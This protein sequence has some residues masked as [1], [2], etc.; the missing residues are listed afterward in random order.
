MP[1]NPQCTRCK[2]TTKVTRH[3]WSWLGGKL[4]QYYQC[5]GCG[6]RFAE[7]GA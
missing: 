6:L 1:A 7:K 3:G 2:K 5:Q 4:T